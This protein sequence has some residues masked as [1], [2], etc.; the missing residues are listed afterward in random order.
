MIFNFF[1]YLEININ[2]IIMEEVLREKLVCGKEY[3]IEC[4]TTD[5]NKQVISHSPSYKMIAK[6]EKL[7]K[8]SIFFDY[9]FACFSNFRKIQH[10]NNKNYYDRYVELN[11]H[12]K[13]YEISEYKVQKNMESRAYNMVLKKIVKDEYFIPIDVM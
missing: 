1:I 5:N 8:S 4:F 6:F 10:K 9:T 12:W 7:K 11:C 2:S 13:F 3:Y